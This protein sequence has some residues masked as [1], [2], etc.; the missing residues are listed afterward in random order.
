KAHF[1]GSTGPAAAA[2]CAT[3]RD[4]ARTADAAAKRR[5]MAALLFLILIICIWRSRARV[6]NVF[7][8]LDRMSVCRG[9]KELPCAEW[10]GGNGGGCSGRGRGGLRQL[11]PRRSSRART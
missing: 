8:S 10:N 2:A 9:S 5:C 7:C 6:V 1:G 4:A 11:S 3:E